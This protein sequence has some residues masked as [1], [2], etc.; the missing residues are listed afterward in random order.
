MGLSPAVDPN[1]FLW[2]RKPQ[3]SSAAIPYLLL[4]RIPHT[5]YLSPMTSQNYSSLKV[6]QAKTWGAVPW[7]NPSSGQSEPTVA[8]HA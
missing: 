1:T 7:P 2:P 4:P 3:S 6:E 5:S 8:S